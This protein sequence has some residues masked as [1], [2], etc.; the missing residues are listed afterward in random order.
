MNK[1]LMLAALLLFSSAWG[2]SAETTYH[3][4]AKADIK[5][6]DPSVPVNGEVQFKEVAGGLKIE[7]RIKEAP[8]G[9]HGFHIHEFGDLANQGESAGAHYN[10][11]TTPHGFIP[12]G[13]YSKSHA[14][15]LGNLYIESNGQGQLS[16]F[17][18]GL[19]IANGKYNILGRSVILHEKKDEFTQPSGN[20][21][22]RIAGGSIYLIED[23]QSSRN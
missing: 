5:G 10:P 18:P 1:K 13:D 6:L 12:S 11:E 22:A 3:Y 8:A 20:A 9:Y 16:L 4:R 15:D 23:K 21:G 2:F 19:S 17:V 7:V 14:G